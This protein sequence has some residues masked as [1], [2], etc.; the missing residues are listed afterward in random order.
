MIVTLRKKV[1]YLSFVAFV[2]ILTAMVVAPAN[3]AMGAGPETYTVTVGGDLP[4]RGGNG[5]SMYMGYGPS[6]ILITA[7]D[8]I[9][10][11]AL[12]GPHTVTAEN[13]TADGKPLFDSHPKVPFPLPAFLFGPG[14]FIPPGGTFV[15]DTGKLTP[16]TYGVLCSLHQDANM[17]ATLTITKQTAPEGYQF[18]V[19]TGVSSVSSEVEAF[20]PKNITVPWGTEVLFENLSGFEPHT[21]VSVVA[22][23]NGTRVIGT[24]FDSSPMLVPP[25]LTW[26]QVPQAN[27]QAVDQLGGAMFPL[28]GMDTF[29]YTFNDPGT[30]MYYCK[31]HSLVENGNIAG[32]VGE[33]IVLPPYAVA[34][35]LSNLSAQN[36]QLSSQ[37]ATATTLAIGGIALGIIG[38]VLAIWATRRRAA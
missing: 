8:T 30:Y 22:L 37:L 29:T 18:P 28:P 21:V 9:I 5:E 14:G 11:K 15:L 10:W 3:V 17:Q 16:G 20:N 24:I 26:D 23:A 19:V 25:G 13:L 7:G 34:S 35:D 33:V 32:M 2:A 6:V 4:N 1:R 31:Y 36:A 27:A 12:D 38:I